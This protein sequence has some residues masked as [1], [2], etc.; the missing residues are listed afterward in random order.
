MLQ[1]L[2]IFILIFLQGEPKLYE[3]YAASGKVNTWQSLILKQ[4]HT[5]LFVYCYDPL[6]QNRT[7]TGKWKQE[8]TK[9]V[10]EFDKG[11]YVHT[12]V[13][14]EYK[15][16]EYGLSP[17]ISNVLPGTELLELRATFAGNDNGTTD[18]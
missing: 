10:L 18:K 5:Y 13:T 14:A 1:Y 8:N 9:L 6:K 2:A 11:P 7:L 17:V 3:H 15:I 4:D 16:S 12:D